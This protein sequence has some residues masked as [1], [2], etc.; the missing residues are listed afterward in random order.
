M[1]DTITSG[2]HDRRL[3]EELLYRWAF[4]RDSD[5]WEALAGCFHDDARIRISWISDTART[6]VARSQDMARARNPGAHMKHLIAAPWIETCGTRAFARC[7]V[8]LL[9]RDQVDGIW[10]DIESHVRFFDRIEK[11][12]GVW[13]ISERVG[14]YDKD[15][16]D[17]VDPTAPLAPL[18]AAHPM[19]D[20]LREARWLCW[21]L[22]T[23]GR[24]PVDGVITTYSA[25]EKLLLRDCRTWLNG[26]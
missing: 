7:N 6:F 3:V 1:N 4:A 18:L 5:D 25:E 22:A 10:V 15:R 20:F 24:A 23:K 8:L 14:V 21:W 2:L 16:L 19:G 17:A 11:R 12:D 9:I 13:R 26:G